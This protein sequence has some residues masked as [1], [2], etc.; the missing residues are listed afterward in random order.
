MQPWNGSGRLWT[1]LTGSKYVGTVLEV[2]GRLWEASNSSREHTEH[3][4]SL[5]DV[6]NHAPTSGGKRILLNRCFASPKRARWRKSQNRVVTIGDST[7]FNIRQDAM[8]CYD[9]IWKCRNRLPTIGKETIFE[10]SAWQPMRVQKSSIFKNLTIFIDGRTIS[11]ICQG[12]MGCYARIWKYR[13]RF[14][15]IGT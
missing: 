7:I 8:G 2:S 3:T 9:D 11:E 14:P 15:T 5:P 13:N 6:R 1:A 10:Y 12:S 4:P